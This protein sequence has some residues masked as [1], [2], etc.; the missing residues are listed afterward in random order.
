MTPAERE[1]LIDVKTMLAAK[2]RQK[3][4]NAGSVPKR[5]QSEMKA[6]SYERQVETLRGDESKQKAKKK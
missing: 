3:A 6:R 2:Y 5:A 4:K 1:N